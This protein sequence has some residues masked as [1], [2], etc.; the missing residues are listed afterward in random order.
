MSALINPIVV[1]DVFLNPGDF[2]FHCP[3]L[4][5]SRPA[6]LKTLLGSCVSVVLWHPEH[7]LA[8][9]SHSVLSSNNSTV[10]VITFDGKYCDQAV[11]CF[12]QEITRK[13][14]HPQ[15]FH[16]YLVGGGDMFAPRKGTTSI[17][18]LNIEAS[19]HHLK[20]AGFLIRAEHVGLNNYRKVELDLSS[21]IVTVTV[22][23]KHINLTGF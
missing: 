4:G 8:G 13:G 12:R 3:T 7:H 17:G 16:T 15:Q 19:R 14:L 18:Q 9:M 1:N 10:K 20:Q 5:G 21:G 23:N 22:A 2:H 11:A 6:R